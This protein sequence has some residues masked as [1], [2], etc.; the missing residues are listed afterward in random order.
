[1]GA[2]IIKNAKT[3]NLGYVTQTMTL[4]IRK[5]R[6]EGFVVE[7]IRNEDVSRARSFPLA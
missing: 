7:V 6:K 4:D 3:K 2:R 1:M 5:L